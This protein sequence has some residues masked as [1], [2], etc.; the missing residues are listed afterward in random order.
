MPTRFAIYLLIAVTSIATASAQTAPTVTYVENAASILQ[1]GLPGAGIAQG[2]I[3]TLYGTG[4][5]PASCNQAVTFPLPTSMCGVS[6]TVTVNGASSSPIF[7]GVY[8]GTQ[9]NAIL[10]SSTPTGTGTVTAT[11][12]S[13]TSATYPI[14]VTDAA[15]GSFTTNGQ[16]FGQASVTDNA[17]GAL[18]TIIH[19]LHPGDI[20]VLWGTGLGAISGSDAI[21]PT[22]GNVGSPTVYV[23]N[24]ALTPGTELLYAGRSPQFPGLDQID[25][26]VPP[27]VN[28]CSVPIAV[29]ASGVVGNVG[30]I[31][32]APAGQNTCTDSVMG[33][34]LV[35]KLAAGN[36]VNFGYLRME[37]NANTLINL[38]TVVEGEGDQAF[39][40]FSSF[41]PQ[42]AFLAAYGVSSGYCAT[43]QY[44][45]GYI[46]DSTMAAVLDAGS[47]LNLQSPYYH[48]A[49]NQSTNPPGYYARQ[50][51]YSSG[52]WI[53]NGSNYSASGTGGGDV[54]AFTATLA[55]PATINGLAKFT[56][57][58]TEQKILRNG[59]LTVQWTG[60]D[61][62]LENGNVTIA[63]FSDST[64]SFSAFECTAPASA[65]SF[66]IPGWILST[67][68]PSQAYPINGL[69]VPIAYIWIGQYGNPVEFTATGLDRGIFEYAFYFG[70]LVSFQ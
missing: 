39:A 27:G 51:S 33:Q 22:A 37:R 53:L 50:L 36:P 48:A 7:L 40:T 65:Q 10:P 54:G 21:P 12:K 45:P 67:L 6:L 1:P 63:G 15:F 5:G 26:I 42:T 32:V 18:N 4:L 49:W 44:G 11:Y 47:S 23:G 68:P 41:S 35:N 69:T 2:S 31:S 19:P 14:Q 64:T 24:T 3:F 57:I 61:P 16:G 56:G 13:L 62:S 17:T 46:S 60:G 29:Q 30:T 55:T 43:S 59:D 38:G 70:Y 28:G 8:Y 34:D 58:T 66:T 20:G 52:S 9:I 25:F